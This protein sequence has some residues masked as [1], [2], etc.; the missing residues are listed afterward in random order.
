MGGHFLVEP[1]FEGQN[2]WYPSEN[3]LKVFNPIIGQHMEY[4]NLSFS[5][6]FFLLKQISNND[7][8][9]KSFINEVSHIQALL[10]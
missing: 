6:D 5:F 8:K 7:G 4:F 2:K 1:S 9:R 3:N 10:F